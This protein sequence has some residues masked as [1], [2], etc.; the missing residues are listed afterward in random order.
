M[1]LLKDFDNGSLNNLNHQFMHPLEGVA[2]EGA[3]T[4]EVS[5]GKTV[6]KERTHILS[7][8][9]GLYPTSHRRESRMGAGAR[10]GVHCNVRS[11]GPAQREEGWRLNGNTFNLL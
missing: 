4:R 11:Y 3:H 9:E 1:F 6:A 2:P 7:S 8:L 5:S 10:A